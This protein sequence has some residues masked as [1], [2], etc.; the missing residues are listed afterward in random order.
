M[1]FYVCN[2]KGKYM[3]AIKLLLVEDDPC[4]RMILGLFLKDYTQSITI[5]H[6]AE[7]AI[8]AINNGEKYDLIIS[9]YNLPGK[10]GDF[11]LKK[12]RSEG[13]NTPYI[14]LSANED[15]EE[16]CPEIKSLVN[17]VFVKAAVCK[18]EL[19]IT[20]ESLLNQTKKKLGLLRSPIT[21]SI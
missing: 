17:E 3:S 7:S 20:I 16:E 4:Y 18:E 6:N 11:L 21:A 19:V 5:H 10:N 15:V 9:D 8:E 13:D 1:S 2:A 14:I 12:L